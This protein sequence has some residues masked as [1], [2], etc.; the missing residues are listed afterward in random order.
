MQRNQ[1]GVK[2]WLSTLAQGWA[3]L[4]ERCLEYHKCIHQLF[5]KLHYDGTELSVGSPL[6]FPSAAEKYKH[7]SSPHCKTKVSLLLFLVQ[8]R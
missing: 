2:V 3:N 5:L 7:L 4:K 6:H 1:E 8:S